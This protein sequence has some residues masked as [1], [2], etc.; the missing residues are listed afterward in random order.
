M[1][2]LRPVAVIIT[3]LP[4][5]REAVQQHL[6]NVAPEPEHRGSIYRRGIFDERSDPWDVVVAEIGAGNV[7]AAAEVVRILDHYSPQVAVFVGI[8]GSLKDLK[9]GDVVA[10]TKV[11]GYE[12]GKDET[13]FKTR[14]EVQLADYRLEQ[15][16][17]FEAGEPGWRQRIKG[18][19]PPAI[20]IASVA[21]IAAGQKVVASHLSHTYKLIRQHYGD[22]LAVEMEG[23]GFLLAV[24]MNE[25]TQGIVVRGIS[26]LVDDKD[27]T[28]DKKWQ[29]VAARHAA[30]FAFELLAKLPPSESGKVQAVSA[31]APAQQIT[32]GN[33]TGDNNTVNVHQHQGTNL[34]EIMRLVRTT[35]F[36][37]NAE[38][39]AAVARMNLGELE[40]AIHILEDLRRKRWDTL[41]PREKYRLAANTG[42]A[43]ERKGE[44][45][46]AAQHYMEAKQHQPQDE[47][48]RAYEAIAYFHLGDKAKAFE[49]AGE[50]LKN[51]PTC[52]VAIAVRI[53]S[54][55]PDVTLNTLE[56]IVPAAL[57]DELD[58]LHA[59]G[60]KAFASGD[61]AATKRIVGTA[62]RLHPDSIEIKE[63]QAVVIVQE[64]TREEHA[65]RVVNSSRLE[66][67][68]ENLSAGLIKH[69]GHRDEA[70]L[71]Y[72]R[73]E[74]YD[75]LGK[76][77]E[78]ETD[79]RA[80]CDIDRDEPDVV[81]RFVL[82]LGRHDRTKA[83]I[84]ALQR[85]G[86]K[87]KK[88][89]R[90]RLLLSGLLS[91][92][93]EKGDLQLAVS[94]LQEALAE[95]P[96][97]EIR[98]EMVSLLMNL[99]GV[100]NQHDKAIAYLESLDSTFLR[101]AAFMAIRAQAHLR[102]GRKDEA[103]GNAVRA[104]EALLAD[105]SITDRMRVA[106]SLSLIGM[107]QESLKQWKEILKPDHVDPFVYKAL[108]LARET[109]DDTFIM[110]F[111]KK[112]RAAGALS[113]F[114]LELEVV[115]LEK[116]GIF[117]TA[118]EVMNDYLAA[119]TDGELAKVFRLRL[120]LLGLRI[121]K[122]EM[123]ESDLAKLPPVESAPVKIGVATAH[124]LLKGA[125]P[126]RGVEYAYE[127]VRRHFNDPTARGAY[128]GIIG[129]G[130]DEYHFPETEVVAPGCAVKYR[131]DDTSEEKW[132]IIENAVEP[133]QEREEYDP[134][135]VWAKELAGQRVDGKFYLRHDPFQSRTATIIGIVSKYVYRKFEIIDGWE[136]RF[137]GEDFFV[138]KYSSPTNPD[139][140]PDVSLILQALDLKEKHKEKLHA[141]YRDNPISATTFAIVSGAGLLESLS[142][143]ASEGT[144]PIRCCLGNDIELA[145]ADASLLDAE[146][147]VL[148]PS[149]LATLYFSDQYE[150]L[151]LLAGKIALCDSALDEYGELRRKFTN[152]TQGF[153]GK[154]KGKYLFQEDDPAERQRQEQRLD[155]FLTKIR[156]LVTRKTGESLAEQ[157]PERR[158]ELIRLFGQPTAE[159]MA[160][161]AATG[162]VLWTDDLAVAE[163][164]R[165]RTGIAKRV[166]SQL[167]FRSV[168]SQQGYTELT[169]FLIQWRYYFTRMDPDIV[170]AACRAGA[171][172]PDAPVLKQVAEWLSQPELIHE[173][174]IRVCVLSLRLLWKEELESSQKQHVARLFL[175]AIYRRNDGK[176]TIASIRKNLSKIFACDFTAQSECELAIKGVLQVEVKS[177]D[178][179][180]SKAAWAKVIPKMRI[181]MGLDTEM[182]QNNEQTKWES[183][184]SSAQFDKKRKRKQKKRRP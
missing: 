174:A 48:A 158:E 84:E 132:L 57:G 136:E 100:Q 119:S 148:D 171:W 112:L 43:L 130:D 71:R 163:F 115:T 125:H 14:A 102:A 117:E 121:E 51:H 95:K 24:R 149:A 75:L 88:D 62:L 159:A 165:E 182:S 60:W 106:E 27:D 98:T 26:D 118:I 82:F 177:G 184:R 92:R 44:F 9:H 156:R 69:R 170:I 111:C 157:L 131:V 150:K 96:E 36:D 32:L 41:T 179:A 49:L 21:P 37:A 58:I 113:P 167:V 145:R 139:G 11:Y 147:I 168:A 80:A 23:H 45:K 79:F 7:S 114:T 35:S 4:L 137:P 76:V 56:E 128:V 78:A 93:K 120:S 181:R 63:M 172:N 94:L 15:L 86:D 152:P 65:S 87:A 33:I 108:E 18:D 104:A 127:L 178:V 29:P 38:I 67:A 143:I 91:E 16:A 70:R 126:S 160:L 53:G 73:A 109:G 46:K 34:Q 135:H 1:P 123:V 77:E 81:R 54:A 175:R 146:T 61:L 59:L 142:H 85:Q 107:K 50:I 162:A 97:P 72:N 2:T 90:N 74:A 19:S 134:S 129:L 161:A 89:H 22:A 183:S 110:S 144:L 13:E 25:V 3:A 124:V 20:P 153:V 101:P 28:N 17:R 103:A 180:A 122:P 140:T 83:A 5:E 40:I 31:P 164:G 6:R 47:K 166:W 154:F 151:E 30:A 10:S 42:H 8:A 99:L 52:S 68:V 105:S 169:L 173:G 12:S 66:L 55:P 116:Y 155:K 64:G 176:Y 138:R 39:D 141:I 133:R